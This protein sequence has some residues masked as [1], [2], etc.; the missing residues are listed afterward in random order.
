[1]NLNLTSAMSSYLN[2]GN[3]SSTD[4]LARLAIKSNEDELADNGNKL[5]EASLQSSDFSSLSKSLNNSNHNLA[6][7]SNTVTSLDKINNILNDIKDKSA[8]IV[9]SSDENEKQKIKSQIIGLI[10]EYDTTIL[11][12]SYKGVFP[13]NSDGE[14]IKLY[15]GLDDEKS[16]EIHLEPILSKDIGIEKPYVLGNFKDGFED[17]ENGSKLEPTLLTVNIKSKGQEE[18]RK[19]ELP[20]SKEFKEKLEV[21]A[22]VLLGI[23]NQAIQIINQSKSKIG[24]G[25]KQLEMLTKNILNLRSNISSVKNDIATIDFENES[26]SF[27]KLSVL[28]QS[29]SLLLSQATNITKQKVQS[30]VA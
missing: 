27:T 14:P 9:T 30:L 21:Q 8:D 26:I 15:A 18:T 3:N 23:V 12:T 16:V 24:E 19:I 7:L 1:M 22:T 4:M 13:L 28:N 29:G 25:S 17:S 6:M 20:L 10:K 2:N 5:E 11:D